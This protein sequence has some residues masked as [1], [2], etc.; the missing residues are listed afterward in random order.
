MSE[1]QNKIPDLD[2]QTLAGEYVLGTLTTEQRKEVQERLAHDAALSKAIEGWRSR[3]ITLTEMAE[4]QAPS[5]HLFDRIERSG[6]GRQSEQTRGGSVRKTRGVSR[7]DNASLWRAVATVLL[8]ASV[9]LATQLLGQAPTPPAPAFLAVLSSADGTS[10]GWV[11]QASN[12][13]GIA[14]VPMGNIDVPPGKVLQFWTQGNDWQGPISLGLA[15]PRETLKVPVD[16]LP[17][18]Q[19]DQLFELS[20]EKAGGSPTSKPS[21][22]ILFSGRTV[23]AG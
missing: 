1:K 6:D 12:I 2:V 11:V 22:P 3:L 4:S 17:T 14:L 20:L 9:T 15:A 16:R 5:F 8:A 21:G 13:R 7:W 10:A 18:L 23:K 19:A